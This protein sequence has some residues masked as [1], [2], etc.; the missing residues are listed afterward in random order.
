M[1]NKVIRK[2]SKCSNCVAEKLKCLRQK[3]NKKIVGTRLIQNY[4]YIKD[5][6]LK[7]MLTYCLKF[8]TIQNEKNSK[9]LITRNCKKM[10]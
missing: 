6:S 4:L 3:S 8:K 5:K 10:L 2:A 9:L 7:N 1:T